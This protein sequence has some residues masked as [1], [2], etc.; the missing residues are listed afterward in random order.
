MR[1]P[2]THRGLPGYTHGV[3]WLLAA[4]GTTDDDGPARTGD[5]GCASLQAWYADA[6]GDGAGDPDNARFECDPGPGWIATTGDCDD[7]D[8]SRYEGA[9][10]SCGDALDSDCD[11]RVD[12]PVLEQVAIGAYGAEVP[13]GRLGGLAVGPGAELGIAVPGWDKGVVTTW[14][15][16]WAP[17]AQFVGDEDTEMFGSWVGTTSVL[18]E[19]AWI[20]ADPAI[21]RIG[22]EAGAVWL[23]PATERGERTATDARVLIVGET[24]DL[25]LASG[26]ADVDLDQ[27]G[28]PEL[29]LTGGRT[30]T[31][32]AL[33]FGGLT[34]GVHTSGE[35]GWSWEPPRG[36]DTTGAVLL[37]EDLDADGVDELVIGLPDDLG[38]V[39]V[40]S[41]P[42]PTAGVLTD[43]GVEVVGTMRDG[44]LGSALTAGDGSGD[45]V[46]ELYIGAPGLDRVYVLPWTGERV[47]DQDI[48]SLTHDANA[49]FGA[50][51]GWIADGAD[52]GLLVAAPGGDLPM[53]FRYVCPT[54]LEAA[55]VYVDGAGSRLPWGSTLA[56]DGHAL[57]L[58]G[59]DGDGDAQV[60]WLPYA[61]P[62]AY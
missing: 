3:W 6:D 11:G 20:V 10:E 49:D 29:V 16:S 41:A 44:A 1:L 56:T 26:A 39:W 45:G 7:A 13:G 18:G 12:A 31:I 34:D 35:A 14:D 21:E 23:F 58:G 4:C 62:V 27:D 9:P 60:A 2:L 40:L 42:V 24:D 36:A 5:A 33:A 43:I 52:T 38:E 54:S 22:S 32:A 30:S 15:A 25:A 47:T 28:A 51:L 48:V 53:V 8:P 37:G 50:G 61:D 17:L 55:V 19:P 57:A 46:P 59:D